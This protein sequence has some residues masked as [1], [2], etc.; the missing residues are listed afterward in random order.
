MAKRWLNVDA[1]LKNIFSNDTKQLVKQ[2]KN[3]DQ[4]LCGDI[5]ECDG[6][7]ED[8]SDLDYEEEELGSACI[9]AQRQQNVHV[10][11]NFDEVAPSKI[12][13]SIIE[14]TAHCSSEICEPN[15]EDAAGINSDYITNDT[16]CS[17]DISDDPNTE[18]T[19]HNCDF[20]IGETYTE[21]VGICGNYY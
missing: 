20:I 18:D 2:D 17:S 15:T 3:S 21:D 14:Y 8:G 4:E 10:S 1:V 19:I 5:G 12:A 7:S 13:K 6:I 16:H 9:Q 11:R